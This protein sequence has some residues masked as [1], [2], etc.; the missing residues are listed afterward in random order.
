MDSRRILGKTL[1]WG[2]K[3][4]AV[5]WAFNRAVAWL[6]PCYK[7]YV[8]SGYKQFRSENFHRKRLPPFKLMLNPYCFLFYIVPSLCFILMRMSQKHQCL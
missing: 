6:R 3:S 7:G 5:Y 4:I 2:D 8:C 1:E